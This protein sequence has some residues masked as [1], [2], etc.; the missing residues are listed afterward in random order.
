VIL[1]ADC[2]VIGD[3]ASRRVVNVAAV[4]ATVVVAD[5]DIRLLFASA[6]TAP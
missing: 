4:A 5:L 2:R 3:L 6:G 1:T